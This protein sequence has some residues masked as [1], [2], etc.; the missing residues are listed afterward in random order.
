VDVTVHDLRTTRDQLLGSV[1]DLAFNKAGDVLAYTVDAAVKD[2]N[3]LFALDFASGRVLP[4][5]N[6][7]KVYNRLTWNER[8]TA[9]AV[10]KGLD[11]EK[12]R[13]RNN[14]LVVY[15]DVRAA[16][17]AQGPALAPVVL[18]PA[19]TET[20]PKGW[21]VSDRAVVS[22]SDDSTRVY[23]GMKEQVAT[24]EARRPNRDENADVDVWNTRDE[25]IQSQQMVRAEAERNFTYRS[26]FLPA[27]G[28]FV[29]LT[30]PTMR[31]IDIALTGNWAV[32][33]DTRGQVTDWG[34]QTADLYR[35]NTMT[36]ERTL[37]MKAAMTGSGLIG[38][39]PNGRL[40]L[41]WKD[42]RFQAWDL[43]AGT[44]RTL[45]AA[46]PVSFVDMEF[47]YPGPKPSYGI[48]GYTQDASAVIVQ[49]RYDLWVMPLDG[50]APRNLTNGFGAKNEV[51]LRLARLT[52]L[53]LEAT[54]AVLLLRFGRRRP[55][56]PISR[57]RSHRSMVHFC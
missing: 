57:R 49:H 17:N 56:R 37:M 11:V 20:F 43:A 48:A 55:P 38:L 8:G 3:G 26:A 32:G 9:L 28:A 39:S 15:P 46:T 2:T 19:K 45:A 40:S 5:E 54:L 14:V 44:T 50:S 51:R 23:F 12:M 29:K 13:E 1:G 4:L 6:D 24:P 25:R 31:E 52:P 21:V 18:D 36:G 47:D 10:L 34:P 33:R 7:A 41:Y 53:D 35:V 16:I 42:N 27:T 30:D 22:W